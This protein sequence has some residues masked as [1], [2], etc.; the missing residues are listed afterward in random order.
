MGIPPYFSPEERQR[1]S[2]CI[3]HYDKFVADLGYKNCYERNPEHPDW[4]L[5]RE[6]F[7]AIDG[8]VYKT[9]EDFYK[10]HG[11]YPCL[12]KDGVCYGLYEIGKLLNYIDP[13]DD[14]CN[15]LLSRGYVRAKPLDE[16]HMECIKKTEKFY[17]MNGFCPRWTKNDELFGHEQLLISEGYKY[18][19]GDHT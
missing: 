10:G 9:A 8:V 7:K 19:F 18:P 2:E 13:W 3:A 17:H 16:D 5:P 4:Y 15:F 1:M 11:W 12:E 6:G 14:E